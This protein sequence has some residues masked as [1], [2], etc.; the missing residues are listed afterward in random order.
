MKSLFLCLAFFALTAHADIGPIN[1]STNVDFAGAVVP[2]T[3][4][5]R[6]INVIN[7][8]GAVIA[9]GKAVSLDLS[10]DNGASATVS[11]TAGLSPLC[12]M[13]VSCAIGKLCKCQTYGYAAAGVFDSTAANAVAGSRWYM[14]TNNAGFISAR[15]ADSAS[16]VPGGIFY[17][18]AS[19]S[20]SVE[21]FI[22]L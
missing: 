1:R 9:I 15:S 12:V 20:G 11:A 14:S 7:S 6:F 17:D 13:A 4:E 8:S 19:A 5:Q 21:I 2:G 18:A 16:E 22:D 3:L 10:A